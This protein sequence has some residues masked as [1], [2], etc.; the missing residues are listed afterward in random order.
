VAVL[1]DIHEEVDMGTTHEKSEAPSYGIRETRGHAPGLEG[2]TGRLRIE[3]GGK[4]FG[5]LAVN[6]GEVD[7]VLGDGE[8][9]TVVYVRSRADLVDFLQ[10]ELNPVVALLQGRLS[11]EGDQEL[12]SRIIL[13]L[14]E[15][16]PFH[17]EL[18]EKEEG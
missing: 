9:G 4:L 14:Q 16:S 6:D 12:A 3:L 1:E 2:I 18:A 8:A 15:G 17:G 5:V 7:F 11:V 10:G 13:G